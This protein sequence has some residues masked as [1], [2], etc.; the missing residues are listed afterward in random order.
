MVNAGMI[1]WHKADEFISA[2]EAGEKRQFYLKKI[3]VNDLSVAGRIKSRYP[4]AEIVHELSE[5]VDDSSI[6]L[7]LLS[8]GKTNDRPVIQK[9]L[10]AGKQL[11]I[12]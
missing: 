9:I 12:I 4:E 3:L 11:R 5:I 6:D 8:F 2:S 10:Q 7:V 1:Y